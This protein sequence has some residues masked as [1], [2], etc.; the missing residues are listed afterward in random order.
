MDFKRRGLLAVTAACALAL[1]SVAG[2]AMAQD[3]TSVRIGYAVSKTG[4][5]AAGANTT[6]IPNYELWAK[7]VEAA[8]GLTL[9]DGSK[10][11]LEI[12]AYDDRSATEDLVRSVERLARQD[13]VDFILAPWGTGFNLAVA[14]LF[15]RFGYPQL[16]GTSVVPN[17]DG[18]SDRWP[19]SF[20]LLGSSEAYAHALVDVLQP[21]VNSGELN[22]KVAMISIADG[23]GIELSAGARDAFE[24][25]GFDLV[26]DKTYPLG[27][28]DFATLLQEA[29]ASGADIFVAYSYPG[30]TFAI[31]AQSKLSS[32]NPK[33]FHPGV[34]TNFPIYAPMNDG[35][36]EGVMSLGGIDANSQAIQDYRARHVALLEKEPDSWASP[37]IYASLQMLQQAIGR[38]GLDRE[39]VS[40]EL[41]SGTFDTILGSISLEENQLKD[42]WYI[43]QWQDGLFVGISPTDKPGAADAT[44]PK[45]DWN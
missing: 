32:Y 9:P 45:P 24:E 23:F 30:D 36:V 31:T 4:V 22:G 12:I 25:A 8:D 33:V 28:Q 40:E 2:M 14:P 13:E 21:A 26:M 38:K 29:E 19:N 44:I 3:R 11:P 27:T 7:D 10:L 34:G 6:T 17:I 20:W 18:L 15:A 39:A 41:A 37:V 42:M 5:N 16:A 1:T 43:G 35:N